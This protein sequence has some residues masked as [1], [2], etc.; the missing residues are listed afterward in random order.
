MSYSFTTTLLSAEKLG[1]PESLTKTLSAEGVNV[2][3]LSTN[4]I[5]ISFT[6]KPLLTGTLTLIN[7]QGSQFSIDGAYSGSEFILL[8]S[9]PVSSGTIFTFLSSTTAG[10]LS[11]TGVTD[12]SDAET[13]RLYLYGYR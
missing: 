1:P 11:A 4:D 9:E 5:G 12:F 13:R 10:L 3:S 6:A 2:I 7:V 8:K